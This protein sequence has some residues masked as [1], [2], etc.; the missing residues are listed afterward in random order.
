MKNKTTGILA[1]TLLIGMSSLA[2][3]DEVERVTVGYSDLNIYDSSDATELYAR[4]KRAA[5]DACGVESY[6]RQRDLKQIAEAK[7]CYKR[8]LA[9]AVQEVDSGVLAEIHR[10]T[11]G[12]D[13]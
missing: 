4:I 5:R 1:A 11:E 7:Q 3:A 6:W 13:A 10:K 8:A 9:K 12:K 2:S